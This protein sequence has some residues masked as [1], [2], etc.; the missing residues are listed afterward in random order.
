MQKYYN[1]K[2]YSLILKKALAWI[3]KT[4]NEKS[5]MEKDLKFIE[6]I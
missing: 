6:C 5:I 1:Q 2:Q 3:K 4:L